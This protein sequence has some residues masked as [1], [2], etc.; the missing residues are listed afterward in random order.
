[1]TTQ[2]SGAGFRT[3]IEARL[4][5]LLRHSSV[6][7]LNEWAERRRRHGRYYVHWAERASHAETL[8]MLQLADWHEAQVE[9]HRENA[10]RHELWGFYGPDWVLA[11][12]HDRRARRLREQALGEEWT[13]AVSLSHDEA[14][15]VDSLAESRRELDDHIEPTSESVR[16][17]FDLVAEWRGVDG[18]EPTAFGE[19]AAFEH[20]LTSGPVEGSPHRD[21]LTA[22]LFDDR[23]PPID[24]ST[25]GP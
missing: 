24:W 22:D 20:L 14:S 1:M 5:G 18:D 4:R 23:F 13:E 2:D 16:L 11:E 17:W 25:E 7:K 10:K 12:S 3:A 6:A 15:I 21:D 9:K 8:A 19:C